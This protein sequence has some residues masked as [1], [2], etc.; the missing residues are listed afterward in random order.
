MMTLVHLT[1]SYFYNELWIIHVALTKIISRK[2]FQNLLLPSS[3]LSDK[4]MGRPEN[5][6]LKYFLE[7]ITLCVV[8]KL[9]SY[10]FFGG[11]DLKIQFSW[12]LNG[13][14]IGTILLL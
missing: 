9:F 14:N 6:K 7:M 2:H 4:L 10:G 1:L 5:L 12:S 3:A 11:G 13:M 8:L